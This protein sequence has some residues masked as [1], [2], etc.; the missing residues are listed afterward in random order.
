MDV[1]SD[2]LSGFAHRPLSASTTIAGDVDFLGQMDSH[3]V[4]F[5]G[6]LAKSAFPGQ[7]NDLVVSVNSAAGDCL[8]THTVAADHF[9][10]CR[11]DDAVALIAEC[12]SSAQTELAR[13][14]AI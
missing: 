10:Y 8:E 11:E 3:G 2:Y 13:N 9:S 12:I 4:A 5:L 6:G 7:L 14:V 1:G